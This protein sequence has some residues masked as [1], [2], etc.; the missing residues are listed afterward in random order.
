M[1][2]AS[3]YGERVLPFSFL[4]AV[5]MSILKF[6]SSLNH[7]FNIVESFQILTIK[8]K[9]FFNDSSQSLLKGYVNIVTK[10]SWF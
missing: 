2:T 10:L 1:H 9:H 4:V 8:M 5:F 7:F 6:M 3:I